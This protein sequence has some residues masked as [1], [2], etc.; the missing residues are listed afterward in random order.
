MDEVSVDE[1]AGMDEAGRRAGV[2]ANICGAGGRGALRAISQRWGPIGPCKAGLG[3][4][5][6]VRAGTGRPGSRLI[7]VW[8]LGHKQKRMF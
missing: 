1:E 3:Q 2:G 5:S 6:P 8:V 7:P 4:G